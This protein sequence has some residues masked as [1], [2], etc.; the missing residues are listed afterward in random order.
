[1]LARLGD[2]RR[3]EEAVI[4]VCVAGGY[5][6]LGIESTR[7]VISTFSQQYL[8]VHSS[9]ATAEAPEALGTG[10]AS[11]MRSLPTTTCWGCPGFWGIDRLGTSYLAP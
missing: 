10:T 8:A 5:F 9:Y 2:L 3:L 4:A 7:N 6:K 1:M 11:G